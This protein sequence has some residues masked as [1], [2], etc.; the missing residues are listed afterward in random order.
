MKVLK[1]LFVF[2]LITIISCSESSKETIEET[3]EDIEEEENDK[4]EVENNDGESINYRDA[5]R[6]FVISISEKGK[7]QNSNF[8]IIPQNGIELVIKNDNPVTD[9]LA[10]IDG[11]GQEDLFYGYDDDNQASPTN[12]TN[13]LKALLDVSKNS[14]NT[15]LVTDYCSSTTNMD[16]S[17]SKSNASNYVSFA[18]DERE[19][20]NI[21][22]YPNPIYNE[23]TAIITNLS[24][25]KNFLYLINPE[26]FNSKA[27][28]INAVTATNYDLIIMDLFSANDIIFTSTEID[29][30]KNKANG[31]KRLVICYMS[32]G[33]AEDYR[34]YWQ[35]S[36]NTTN[37]SWLVEENP[38]WAGNFK[39]QYWNDEWQN[40][41]IGNDDN[42][43]L[44]KILN[45][46]FDGVYLDII[47]AY[48]YFE[49][50]E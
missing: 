34:F 22:N 42:S 27:D 17:Y 40:I 8:A 33:E 32:I 45:A 1:Y 25:V 7:S 11:N 50:I 13:Y 44:N 43:Y 48:E 29:Q 36:W 3:I 46:G 20:F 19:L 30:L 37:P 6:S 49:N 28:F 38:D 35:S 12:E 47:D 26:D 41:I 31:G 10:A 4:E 16:D 14:G 21:P 9:Y 2:I 5:M 18:A 23:N 39:V 15:I 24:E